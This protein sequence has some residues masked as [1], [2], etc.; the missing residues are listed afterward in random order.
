MNS[1]FCKRKRQ[2]LKL[3]GEKVTELIDEIKEFQENRTS[4]SIIFF[5][6]NYILNHFLFR[7]ITNNLIRDL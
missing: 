3:K 7:E 2:A 4:Y 5:L 6:I 1:P